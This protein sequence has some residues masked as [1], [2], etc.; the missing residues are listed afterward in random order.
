MIPIVK[1]QNLTI[2]KVE[3]Q[4]QFWEPPFEELGE[5]PCL[6]SHQAHFLGDGKCQ[7]KEE[8]PAME[9]GVETHQRRG[10]PNVGWVPSLQN[11]TLTHQCMLLTPIG[12]HLPWLPPP[13][14]WLHKWMGQIQSRSPTNRYSGM[15]ARCG[16]LRWWPKM[17][18]V[19]YQEGTNPQ[20][21]VRLIAT[22]FELPGV[23]FA[24]QGDAF[25]SNLPCLQCFDCPH[26]MPPVARPF[27]G[28]DYR[29]Q[30]RNKTLA[31]AQAL[32]DWA[33]KA[34]TNPSLR[35][36]AQCIREM[37]E[38]MYGLVGFMLKD[39]QRLPALDLELRSKPRAM[40]RQ[41]WTANQVKEEE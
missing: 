14:P 21:L 25:W 33:E 31:N 24:Q 19:H 30:G 36:M 34:I 37:Q 35:G 32:Q 2:R 10:L 12:D 17:V 39:L 20:H 38:M 8:W 6:K 3:K 7:G 5:F 16:D 4:V 9:E 40:P 28:I 41:H 15:Q 18:C 22:S 11:H 27:P 29:E 26:Y 13:H 1:C 23:Q